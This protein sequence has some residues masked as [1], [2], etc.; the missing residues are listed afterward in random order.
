MSR[1][2][3]NAD[4]LGY[5]PA[6]NRAITDL[7]QAGLVTSAS[8]LVNLPH[9]EEG[10][11]IAARHPRLSVGVHL[12][13]SKGCPL[14]P[15][16]RLPSLVDE[17]GHFWN[18]AILY[19]R[20]LLRQINWYEVAAELEAQVQ[21]AVRRGLHLDNLDS[22][23]HFH[24]LPPARRLIIDL[25]QRYHVDAWRTPQILATILP[26]DLWNTLLVSAPKPGQL[27]APHYL[28]SLH[29]WGER[30]LDDARLAQLLS[31]PDVTSELVVHPGYRDDPDLPLPDQLPPARRQEEFN[32]LTSSAFAEWL[33][34]LGLEL[35]SFAD[36][37]R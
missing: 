35:V 32:L 20:A 16:A 4:D 33:K 13:L 12:N 18:S 3:I 1:L 23:V 21:W 6:V 22:H 10:A 14:L 28:L 37:A 2:I 36:L 34:R 7:F 5:S 15:A 27:A 19:R 8:I 26:N 30:L 11:Q 31:R 25:A 24:T 17:T 29:Q 9:S